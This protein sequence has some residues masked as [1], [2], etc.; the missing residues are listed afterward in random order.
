MI[1][2]IISK[3]YSQLTDGEWIYAFN[4]LYRLIILYLDFNNYYLMVL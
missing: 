4:I 1:H 2:Q 3:F